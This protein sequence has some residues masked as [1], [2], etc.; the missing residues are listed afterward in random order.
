M[1]DC[2]GYALPVPEITCASDLETWANTLVN[3]LQNAFDHVIGCVKDS[4]YPECDICV[5]KDDLVSCPLECNMVD[6]AGVTYGEE[7][8]PGQLPSPIGGLQPRYGCGVTEYC[9]VPELID[10]NS[11]WQIGTFDVTFDTPFD[12]ECVYAKVQITSCHEV[13][14][15]PTP[16]PNLG[17]HYHPILQEELITKTGF[18]VMFK[19]QEPEVVGPGE[20]GG[21]YVTFRYLAWGK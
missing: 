8:G 21:H 17:R 14:T 7:G 12:T 1:A 9:T 2:D 19:T 4:E 3:E 16:G 20:L 13:I 10:V 11:P 18:R 6:F 15:T 5:L